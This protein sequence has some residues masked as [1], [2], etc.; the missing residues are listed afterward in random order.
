MQIHQGELLKEKVAQSKLKVHEIAAQAKLPTSSLYDLY[1]RIDVPRSKLQA[2][3]DV[4]H[5]NIREFYLDLTENNNSLTSEDQAEYYTRAQVEM[6]RRECG[7]L[8]EQVKHLNTIIA[9]LNEKLAALQQ[10]KQG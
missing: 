10:T 8:K 5:I 9:L 2:I 3:C 6:L 4:L 7:F 1:K